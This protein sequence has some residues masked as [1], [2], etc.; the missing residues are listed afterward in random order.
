MYK[1]IIFVILLG[2][3]LYLGRAKIK[4]T[5]VSE[6]S[7]EKIEY[8]RILSKLNDK[9]L[10]LYKGSIDS[11]L[12]L[13][14]KKGDDYYPQLWINENGKI[15]SSYNSKY[16]T[17][18]SDDTKVILEDLD[19]K[20]KQKWNI[21][22][23]GSI[24]IGDL[25][26][27]VEGENMSDDALVV[28]TKKGD[29]KGFQWYT[30]KV[31]V[32]V[33]EEI[34]LKDKKEAKKEVDLGD[35]IK[36]M[37]ASCSYNWWFNVHDMSYKKGEYRNIFNRGSKDTKERNPGVWIT[38][39]E[40]KLHIRSNTTSAEN[41]GITAS[42]F[43]FD[44]N[45]W[46]HLSLVYSDKELV[47]Y[48][49]GQISEKF[50]FKGIPIHR[51]VF[52]LNLS[53]GFD[54]EMANV[55]YINK[56][57]SQDDILKK[58]KLS[59]PEKTCKEDRIVTKIPNNLVK[60]IH[61]WKQNSLGNYRKNEECPPEKLGGST[62]SF[63]CGENSKIESE[64]ELL[65]NQ[66]YDVSIWALSNSLQGMNIR[67]YCGSWTGEWKNVKKTDE[68]KQLKWE[69]LNTD[70][71]KIFGFQM[72]NKEQKRDSLFLPIISIKILKVSNGNIDVKEFRSNGTHPT[73][74]IKD[75]GL[76]SIQGWCALKDKR[77]E[78]YI[79][80]D[81]D[82]IYQI[83]KIHT[84]GRGDYPQWTTEY[85]VEFFDIYYNKWRQYGGR[86]EGNKD[87]NSVK[88]NDVDILTDKV[89][90]YPVSFQ[91][92]PS[93]RLSFSGSIGL[94]DKCNDY[95]VKSEIVMNIIEREK[96]LKLYN[97]ECKKISFHEYEMALEKEK[98]ILKNVQMKVQKAEIDAKTYEVKYKEAIEKIEQLERKMKR[99][100]NTTNIELSKEIIESNNRTMTDK[101]V[102]KVAKAKLDDK[103]Q[104]ISE[105]ES[106][107]EQNSTDKKVTKLPVS[108]D[109]KEKIKNEGLT[110]HQLLQKLVEG[111]DKI[112]KDLVSKESKLVKI[113]NELKS[114]ESSKK[115]I[116]EKDDKKGK[117]PVDK[118]EKLEKNKQ[119]TQKE[120][121]ELKNQLQI[122]QANFSAGNVQIKEGFES[123]SGGVENVLTCNLDQLSPYDIRRHKQYKQLIG[124][125]QKKMKHDYTCEKKDT[126]PKCTPFNNMDIRKHKDYKR[127][128][129]YVYDIA[130]QQFGD[131]RKHKDFSKL[132]KEIQQKTIEEYGRKT[133][134]GYI[135]CPTNCELLNEINIETHPKFR[136]LVRKIVQ[137]TIM[138][139]GEAIP[140]T[141]PTLYRKC[142]NNSNIIKNNVTNS[143]NDMSS[144]KCLKN[145]NMEGF[146]DISTISSTTSSIISPS[147]TPTGI[148][149]KVVNK[150]TATQD[151]FDIRNHR[152][153]A[154]L[155]SKVVP[156][157]KCNTSI[158]EKMELKQLRQKIT[159]K[160]NITGDEKYLKLLAEYKKCKAEAL[161]I[162]KHPKYLELLAKMKSSLLSQQSSAISSS[163]ITRHP[164]INK[165]V[166]KSSL[167]IDIDIRRN[168]TGDVEKLKN[169]LL[170][171][172][173]LQSKCVR[174]FN[175]ENFE[176][177]IVPTQNPTDIQKIIDKINH[178]ITQL[179]TSG[180]LNDK[181]K[182]S[183][184]KQSCNMA[185]NILGQ[186][187]P[188]ELAWVREVYADILMIERGE[189]KLSEINKKYK[190]TATIL[191]ESSPQKDIQK[192]IEYQAS[193]DSNKKKIETE[194][195]ELEASKNNII[196]EAKEII[197]KPTT[198]ITETKPSEQPNEDARY[199]RNIRK[200]LEDEKKAID[201][202]LQNLVL[203]YD[204][205][206]IRISDYAFKNKYLQD[207]LSV[208]RTRC[209]ERILK[210]W[211]EN[212]T[213]RKTLSSRE[214]NARKRETSLET[215]QKELEQREQKISELKSSNLD[216]YQYLQNKIQ[217]EKSVAN[218]YKQE[219]QKLR[220][221]IQNEKQINDK[222]RL[223]SDSQVTKV[224]DECNN[225]V[226]RYRR[227]YEEGEKLLSELRS[228]SLEA[229]NLVEKIDKVENKMA[230]QVEEA[231]AKTQANLATVS[232]SPVQ[233]SATQSI[234]DTQL[235]DEMKKLVK[236]VDDI[237]NKLKKTS[238]T[239]EDLMWYNNKYAALSS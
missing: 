65:E 207:E 176:G 164:D 206:K 208:L 126:S 67:P 159:E 136:Q 138:M 107:S 56:A 236:K 21:D 131:I 69:F 43:T 106:D 98:D 35:V 11:S 114:L 155:M 209:N 166:L 50:T 63:T 168:S 132:V 28:A 116:E 105:S 66:Y 111:M 44:L 158:A 187:N 22:D 52:Y 147:K 117:K 174:R 140:N 70:K 1:Y 133:Q 119:L 162:T 142:S 25:A 175:V 213:I 122:C 4:E 188:T 73:C 182:F 163:D 146:A 210:L 26:L 145:F 152:Q 37:S 77:D 171:L 154:E 75:L 224:R 232:T 18:S 239:G 120:I 10:Q 189:K 167:P 113:E 93:M 33:K 68:W 150:P 192:M 196:E 141:Y 74:S 51:G 71:S 27:H 23:N 173:N 80:A 109:T 137:R 204:R 226:D 223:D 127:V 32:S 194:K 157:E 53:G 112:N 60:E 215:K 20:K 179:E 197:A 203:Q 88:T 59:N 191:P 148:A 125:I 54:G 89:R 101:K 90:I 165:Y 149:A 129:E 102:K 45:R 234:I 214:E 211:N 217:E 83:Q 128:V 151:P 218:R 30:E 40:Q 221:A 61:S 95:K 2:V 198:I 7:S 181:N 46:Y 123:G 3:V 49:D 177:G 76:N 39:N 8:I 15:K 78:Y 143:I 156:K 31:S 212:Q 47:F 134:S 94:K 184:I 238:S 130:K 100:K 97:L 5:F 62:I 48:V 86:L 96:Y 193:I 19:D 216:K 13:N 220:D 228:R 172:Q 108:K 186:A 17:I 190:K 42:K 87:M 230:K 115:A 139:Y 222:V 12:T 237:E 153:Y 160:A 161:D 180:N 38:P 202:K 82:K 41:E 235:I 144:Q 16:I 64:L 14:T 178:L 9:A 6:E 110:D 118:K 227:M 99:D 58:M 225:R 169:E 55:D 229:P 185:M 72:N 199:L 201:I 233:A 231:T 195:K 135:K 29:G 124:D 24:T 81:F 36:S 170:K 205:A 104:P 57:L 219:L 91:S 103:C 84:R 85:R 92:W 34:L 183:E 121:K 200:T 79:E